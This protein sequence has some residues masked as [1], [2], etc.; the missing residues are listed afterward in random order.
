MT[1]RDFCRL[2]R[3]RHFDRSRTK[4]LGSS[5]LSPT[6][7]CASGAADSGKTW[8]MCDASPLQ[9]T[10]FVSGHVLRLVVPFASFYFANWLSS[11]LYCTPVDLA[12]VTG[13][14]C[15]HQIPAVQPDYPHVVRRQSQPSLMSP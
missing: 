1:Q 6:D 3:Y 4:F 8:A 10:T 15:G 13:S 12:I 7:F 5:K 2:M 14:Q 9:E 11:W